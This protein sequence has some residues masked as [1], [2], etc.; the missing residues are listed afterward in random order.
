MGTTNSPSAVGHFGGSGTMIWID[1]PFDIALAA[2]TD[3]DFDQ[4]S[5]EAISAWSLLSDAVIT[6]STVRS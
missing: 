6:A 1:R 4:W 2:L 5:R 3:R